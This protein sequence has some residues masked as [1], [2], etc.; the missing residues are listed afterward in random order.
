MRIA[1][2]APVPTRRVS[3]LATALTA[4]QTQL[5][6]MQSAYLEHLHAQRA[7]AEVRLKAVYEDPRTKFPDVQAARE[8]CA[9]ADMQIREFLA[10]I[11]ENHRILASETTV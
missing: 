4:Y 10:G 6:E 2:Y 3:A 1:G 5:A 11:V 9:E 8:V 7:D